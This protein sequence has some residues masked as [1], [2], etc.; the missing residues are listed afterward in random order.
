MQCETEG[1]GY[2]IKIDPLK[3][4]KIY[5]IIATGNDLVLFGQIHIKGSL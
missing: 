5:K 1:E 4:T 2:V 3:H